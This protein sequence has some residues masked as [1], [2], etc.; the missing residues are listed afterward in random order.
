[1]THHLLALAG[2]LALSLGRPTPA[3]AGPTLE[4]VTFAADPASRYVPLQEIA[5][6]LHLTIRRNP[7]GQCIQF[8]QTTVPPGSL[9]QLNDGRELLHT[10]SLQLAGAAFAPLDPSGQTRI[11]RGFYECTLLTSPKRVEINLAEQQLRAWQ[12][13]RLVLQTHISSGRNNRT[14]TGHFSAGPFRARMH[15]SSRYQN[16]PMPYSVQINGHIFIHG[17]P[18]VPRFPASHG[19]IRLPLDGLN[20]AKFFF[21]WVDNGSPVQVLQGS[22]QNPRS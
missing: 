1:M 16:A 20:P 22:P 21:E 5:D 19:C 6:A 3:T 14:P 12:G 2:L 15:Y 17:Y 8:H 11:R 4:A 10:H 13:R 7:A 18:S 9:K